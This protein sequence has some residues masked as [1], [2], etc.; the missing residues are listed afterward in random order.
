MSP[1]SRQIAATVPSAEAAP[2]DTA[3]GDQPAKRP[4]WMAR[5][6]A[7]LRAGGFPPAG[8]GRGPLSCP[9]PAHAA[10]RE[11]LLAGP[12]L[13]PG[14][15]GTC[16]PLGTFGPSL[17]ACWVRFLFRALVLAALLRGVAALSVAARPVSCKRFDTLGI[18]IAVH[19]SQ[20]LDYRLE[21]G[22][23]KESSAEEWGSSKRPSAT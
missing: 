23:P 19:P 7:S 20:K 22:A 3:L 17:P 15:E 10:P 5:L 9:L 18:T 4:R 12:D 13:E 8:I 1:L 6:A 11:R 14:A 21:T 16:T 2:Q